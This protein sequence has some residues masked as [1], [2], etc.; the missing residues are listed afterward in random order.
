MLSHKTD[1]EAKQ[2]EHDTK[3]HSHLPHDIAAELLSA[4]VTTKKVKYDFSQNND[5]R[6]DQ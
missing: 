3:C 1:E 2:Q 6:V 4:R 5:D